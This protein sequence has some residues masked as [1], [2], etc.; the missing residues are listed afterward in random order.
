LEHAS[1]LRFDRAGDFTFYVQPESAA[2]VSA[3][4]GFAFGSGPSASQR[5]WTRGGHSHYRHS[6]SIRVDMRERLLEIPKQTCITKD[7]APISIDF[8]I[9]LQIVDP[10]ASVV[11]M[12]NVF[13]ATEG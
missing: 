6:H 13:Q 2:R 11:N 4:S 12:Q 10:L 5:P 8:L 1:H 7:N 9:Y 3:L